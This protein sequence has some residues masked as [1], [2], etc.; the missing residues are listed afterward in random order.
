MAEG[1][2]VPVAR[3]VKA[4][5]LDGE[6]S[7]ASLVS[8]PEPLQ[9]G[10]EVWFVPP[11]TSVRSGRVVATRPGPKG[12]LV[13]IDSVNRRDLS[14][15]LVGATIAVREQDAPPPGAEEFDP[16]GIR[17]VDRNRGPLGVLDHVIFTGANDVWVLR[18]GPLGQVL[19]PVIDDSHIEIDE[20]LREARIDLLPGLLDGDDA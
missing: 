11:R 4:H 7:V 19:I 3:V 20:E 15:S 10:L 1:L 12:P 6:L 5:G 16:V 2:F 8:D 18:D 17:V 13:T 14:E 9:P